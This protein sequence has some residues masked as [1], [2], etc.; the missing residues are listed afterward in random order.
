MKKIF[1][2]V[3]YWFH[4]KREKL[5]IK[6]H[7][8]ISTLLYENFEKV[9]DGRIEYLLDDPYFKNV[10]PEIQLMEAY[11]NVMDQYFK[12]MDIDLRDDEFFISIQQ[13]II[14]RDKFIQGRK[15][16][17]N[18]IRKYEAEIKD[19]KQKAVKPDFVKYRMSV[20]KWFKQPLKGK[21]VA[22]FIAIVKLIKE[23]NSQKKTVDN[24]EDN[25]G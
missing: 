1:F 9:L 4:K 12:E 20:E 17:K 2:R 3:K 16:A 5:V 11:D 15:D 6:V 18:F 7:S 23:E 22:E 19:L 8:D 24:G 10:V 14:W 25:E 13:L 21:T